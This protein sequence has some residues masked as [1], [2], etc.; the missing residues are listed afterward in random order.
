MDK[1]IALVTMTSTNPNCLIN[2]FQI[3][4]IHAPTN[5]T[6]FNKQQIMIYKPNTSKSSFQ[7]IPLTNKHQQTP[8]TSESI[9]KHQYVQTI[10]KPKT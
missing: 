10:S 1:Q 5:T 8:S 4:K 7:L 6:M 3:Q 9:Y 2:H